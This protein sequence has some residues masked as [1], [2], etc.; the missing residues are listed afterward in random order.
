MAKQLSDILEAAE[1][2]RDEQTPEANTAERVG[3]VLTDLAQYVGQSLMVSDVQVEADATGLY[4]KLY[5]N[6]D[7]GEPYERKLKLP[8][9]IPYAN[10][11]KSGVLS[12]ELYDDLKA[13]GAVK[14]VGLFAQKSLAWDFCAT[15]EVAGDTRYFTIRFKTEGKYYYIQQRVNDNMCVQEMFEGEYHWCRR[16]RFQDN[17]L[18]TVTEV[19]WW[20][21]IGATGLTYDNANRTLS[22]K[23]MLDQNIGASVQIPQASAAIPGLLA[24]AQYTKLAELASSFRKNPTATASLNGLMSAADKAKLDAMEAR[25]AALEAAASAEAASA[26]VA[27]AEAASEAAE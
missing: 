25:L 2:V 9:A 10:V 8:N 18:Q 20:W 6:D 24:P 13:A 23:N 17:T 16:I 11:K 4:L 21:Q 5:F 15:P 26:E 22:L 19:E 3:G 12:P 14:D 27:S 1:Q 7:N